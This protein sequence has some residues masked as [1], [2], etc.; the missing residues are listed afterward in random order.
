MAEKYGHCL[1][2]EELALDYDLREHIRKLSLLLDL[3]QH[4]GF[5]FSAAALNA[6]QSNQDFFATQK[7]FHELL[8]A[9]GEGEF[10]C[11]LLPRTKQLF[12][13]FL[14]TTIDATIERA[15][16]SAGHVAEIDDASA[17]ARVEEKCERLTASVY[18]EKSLHRI[19]RLVKL[20]DAYVRCGI[21]DKAKNCCAQAFTLLT[22]GKLGEGGDD[23][24]GSSC[25]LEAMIL[26]SLTAGDV[27]NHLD[28]FEMAKMYYCAAL[29][30][31]DR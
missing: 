26:L 8:T 5:T 23:E 21:L 29:S 20:A 16:E 3:Q 18:G 7:P 13:P 25:S 12:E 1:T 22:Q 11:V 31:L 9:L 14:T 6:I 4:L 24:E 27:Y 30:G 2:N 17:A 10:G 19:L 28:D 15:A